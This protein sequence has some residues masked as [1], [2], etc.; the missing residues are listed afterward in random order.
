MKLIQFLSTIY[1]DLEK[2]EGY[3][4]S[5]DDHLRIDEEG[6]VIRS[7]FDKI[8][9]NDIE[10]ILRNILRENTKV[11]LEEEKDDNHPTEALD[12]CWK[13]V[14]R[15]SEYVRGRLE[16]VFSKIR[17]DPMVLTLADLFKLMIALMDDVVL[18]HTKNDQIPLRSYHHISNDTTISS[19]I[20]LARQ[21]LKTSQI[22]EISDS[23]PC[24]LILNEGDDIPE[25]IQNG[26][27]MLLK[28]KIYENLYQWFLS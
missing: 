21:I 24:R 15:R 26:T 5:I 23:I 1:N 6:D 19:Y 28:D 10:N 12:L 11:K 17:S 4:S 2:I 9:L 27:I 25:D 8:L 3:I 14:V 7:I 13:E 16:D 22:E 20:I 18:D